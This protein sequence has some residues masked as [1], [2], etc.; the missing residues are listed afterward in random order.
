VVGKD[1][2]GKPIIEDLTQMPHLLIAGSTGSGKSVYVN[3]IITG[4]L[5]SKSPEELRFI[6]IDL[7]IVELKVYNGIPHLLTPVVTTQALQNQY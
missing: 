6:M 1:I 2:H 7:K 4:L 3:S 5:Y